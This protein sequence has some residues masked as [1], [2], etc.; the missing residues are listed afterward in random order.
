[1][2]ALTRIDLTVRKGCSR[3][4]FV[5]CSVYPSSL[6]GQPGSFSDSSLS[7]GNSLCTSGKSPLWTPYTRHSSRLNKPKSPASPHMVVQK[8]VSKTP[9]QWR[10]TGS[11]VLQCWGLQAE[12]PLQGKHLPCLKGCSLTAQSISAHSWGVQVAARRG[13]NK[14]FMIISLNKHF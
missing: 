12:E 2:P 5:E 10:M 3:P 6:S 13:I 1:M 14:I 11:E 8:H 7:S 4:F 9:F